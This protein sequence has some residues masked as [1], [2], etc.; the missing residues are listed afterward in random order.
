[1]THVPILPYEPHPPTHT[2]SPILS[3]VHIHGDGGCKVE[4][5][6]VVFE[7]NLDHGER[8]HL[9]HGPHW[10]HREGEVG[11]LVGEKLA[12]LKR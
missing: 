1:M 6:H 7:S 8:V 10:A 2:H 5:T 11:G 4:D 3:E 12:D 9:L